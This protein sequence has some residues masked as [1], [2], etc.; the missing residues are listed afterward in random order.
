MIQKVHVNVLSSDNSI[1]IINVSYFVFYILG[2]IQGLDKDEL[3]GLQ[4]II[5]HKLWDMT[6]V[7][8]RSRESYLQ[9]L[10]GAETFSLS[11]SSED[12]GDDNDC[13]FELSDEEL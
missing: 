8:M 4:S 10:A 7:V 12:D 13:Y 9:V 11:E 1:T 6:E 3:N 5:R 2:Y